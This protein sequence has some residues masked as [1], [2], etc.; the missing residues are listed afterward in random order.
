MAR[1]RFRTSPEHLK[2]G[3]GGHRR[4]SR[5]GTLTATAYLLTSCCQKRTIFSSKKKK[6]T[7]FEKQGEDVSTTQRKELGLLGAA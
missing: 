5:I 6:R 2:P 4:A 1:L 7:I 3:A